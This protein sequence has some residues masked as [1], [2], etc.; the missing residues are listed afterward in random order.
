MTTR[1]ASPSSAFNPSTIPQFCPAVPRTASWFTPLSQ[2]SAVG[3]A[4]EYSYQVDENLFLYIFGECLKLESLEGALKLHSW[5]PLSKLGATAEEWR[6]RYLDL[7]DVDYCPPSESKD[8]EHKNVTHFYKA[9]AGEKVSIPAALGNHFHF[10]TVKAAKL[11]SQPESSASSRR[12]REGEEMEANLRPAQFRAVL[13]F[14]DIPL[15]SGPTTKSTPFWKALQYW[16]R[17][18]SETLAGKDYILDNLG[19]ANALYNVK[20]LPANTH[21]AIFRLLE[22]QRHID[23]FDKQIE[24]G[25]TP[26]RIVRAIYRLTNGRLETAAALLQCERGQDHEEGHPGIW[27]EEEDELLRGENQGRLLTVHS[28]NVLERRHGIHKHCIRS[29]GYCSC[30]YH[31]GRDRLRCCLS[32]WNENSCYQP[33]G[34]YITAERYREAMVYGKNKASLKS[35]ADLRNIRS[36]S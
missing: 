30:K 29:F 7:L 18:D 11:G 31:A 15:R 27:T 5:K 24:R 23:F 3:A 36:G 2:G 14:Q 4:E 25:H 34:E 8:C 22:L 33:F 20:V 32:V 17:G 28:N 9:R 10:D 12:R 16:P 13:R 6:Q 19:A 26:L 35:E 21:G 1:T